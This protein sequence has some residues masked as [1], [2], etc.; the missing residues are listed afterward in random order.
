[1]WYKIIKKYYDDNL[2]S[3]EQVKTAV[4]KN[5]ITENEYKNIIGEDYIV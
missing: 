2:W 5:K 1:M 4:I 3:K